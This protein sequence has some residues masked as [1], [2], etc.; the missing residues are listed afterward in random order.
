MPAT[1]PVAPL[2]FDASRAW[3]ERQPERFELAGGVVRL[4]CE[5]TEPA[6]SV[7]SA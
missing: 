6:A 4:I 3:E 7:R 2:S 1:A 5:N